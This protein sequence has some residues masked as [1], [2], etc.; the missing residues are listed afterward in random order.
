M[1]G[2]G[3]DKRLIIMVMG[4]MAVLS[5]LSDGLPGIVDVLLVLPGILIGITFHEF[6]HAYMADRLGD[7]TPRLQGRVS[8]NPIKH[9]DPIGFILLIVARFGW[10][11]PVEIN[12]RRFD[13]K[14]SMSSGEA[15]VSVTGP[16]MN[17]ILAFILLIIL[18]I[19]EIFDPS[20]FGAVNFYLVGF[21]M[22]S[23]LGVLAIAYIMLYYAVI[24]NISLRNI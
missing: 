19:I 2:M 17:F 18:Y 23:E 20:V 14:Y 6:A 24:M 4:V 9:I 15:I 12:P 13:R 11:K 5:I 16:L 1:F 21:D 22:F 3:I 10:G 8:L 7:D